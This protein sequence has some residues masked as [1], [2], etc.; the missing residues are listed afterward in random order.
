MRLKEL[1]TENKLKQSDVAEKLFITQT[2]YSNYEN[3]RTEPNIEML[4]KLADLYNVSIDYLI[5][6]DK[7]FLTFERYNQEKQNL[8][9]MIDKLNQMNTLKAVIYIT[10]LLDGQQAR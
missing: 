8:I 3:G 1:R 2:G 6:R 5:G 4:C 9:K 10:G 7:T